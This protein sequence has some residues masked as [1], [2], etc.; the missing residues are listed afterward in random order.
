MIKYVPILK[1]KQGEYIAYKN[2]SPEISNLVRPL[3]EVTPQD[4]D[5]EDGEERKSIDTHLKDFGKRYEKNCGKTLCF[6]D[7][8][9]IKADVRMV[10]GKLPIEFIFDEIGQKNL[11]AIPVVQIDSDKNF[12]ETIKKI[13]LTIDNGFCLR[14]K[15]EH[16][17]NPNLRLIVDKLLLD[18]DV[19]FDKVDLLLDLKKPTNFE[20][21]EALIGMVK[22]CI[23]NIPNLNNWR[24]FIIS[25]TSFPESMG[26]IKSPMEIRERKE[27][28]LFTGLIKNLQN[29]G[30]KPIFSDYTI[31]SPSYI[32][33]DPKILKPKNR[34]IYT[35]DDC[36]VIYKGLKNFKEKNG[37]SE[38][39][40][41]SRSLMNSKY[42]MGENYSIGDKFI[43]DCAMEKVG[44]GK[45]AKPSTGNLSTWIGVGINHHITKVINDLSSIS[46]L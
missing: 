16:L 42:F 24:S 5:F 36:W 44:K 18:T 22:S 34:I 9:L 43:V 46:S 38:Y 39:H 27:W 13:N 29:G 23:A 41:M 40:E 31:R 2:L 20:P 11:S 15:I 37:A 10:D 30:R 6:I 3:F 32:K 17:F 4:F 35:I 8:S 19:T 7:T 33:V 12:L 25:A 1:W 14:L 21:I 45:N 28:K 26:E